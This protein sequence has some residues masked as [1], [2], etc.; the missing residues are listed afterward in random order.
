[1]LKDAAGTELQPAARK[2]ID[3]EGRLVRDGVRKA[4]RDRQ[5]ALTELVYV[6]RE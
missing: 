6:I 2:T 3:L 4:L 5:T 1:V